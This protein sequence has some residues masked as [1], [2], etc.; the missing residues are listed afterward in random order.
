MLLT[1][2]KKC[3]IP[4]RVVIIHV[5]LRQILIRLIPV[6]TTLIDQGTPTSTYLFPLRV[7]QDQTHR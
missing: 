6:P 2:S 4:L 5:A 1:D 7:L 3:W